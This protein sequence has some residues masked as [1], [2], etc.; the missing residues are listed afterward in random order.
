MQALTQASGL[1]STASPGNPCTF[2]WEK[3]RSWLVVVR[4]VPTPAPAHITWELIRNAGSQAAS[5][6]PWV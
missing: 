2:K 3:Y 4:V 1:E 6:A 5:E